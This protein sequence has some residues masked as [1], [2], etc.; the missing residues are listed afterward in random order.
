MERLE[1][2]SLEQ[3]ISEYVEKLSKEKTKEYDISDYSQ[4]MFDQVDKSFEYAQYT[5]DQ[6]DKSIGYAQHTFG[7][8]VINNADLILFIIWMIVLMLIF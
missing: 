1:D 4:Y 5:F 8:S 6:V 2:K 7:K 3:Q